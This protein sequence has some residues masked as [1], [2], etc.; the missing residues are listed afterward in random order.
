MT[1]ETNSFNKNEMSNFKPEFLIT[2]IDELLINR[3]SKY[4][5]INKWE[6]SND[7][8]NNIISKYENGID[9]FKYSNKQLIKNGNSTRNTTYKFSLA[10]KKQVVFSYKKVG[11]SKTLTKYSV[12]KKSA[13]RWFKLYQSNSLNSNF[14]LNKYIKRNLLKYELN[15]NSSRISRNILIDKINEW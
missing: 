9:F 1:K 7:T 6:I 15:L 2:I 4:E 3:L 8:L 14:Q 11:I 12:S 5:I 13:Y 10:F